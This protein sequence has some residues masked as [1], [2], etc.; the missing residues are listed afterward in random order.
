MSTFQVTIKKNRE[1]LTDINPSNL[2]VDT[3]TPNML[4]FNIS[5][6][7]EKTA[8]L[9]IVPLSNISSFKILIKSDGKPTYNEIIQEGFLYPDDIQ[10]S[11]FANFEYFKNIYLPSSSEKGR[12]YLTSNSS[13]S[14]TNFSGT[15]Y[16]G[17]ALDLTHT[18]T[19]ETLQRDY[20]ACLGSDKLDCVETVE[21]TIDI[22]TKQLGC[23][24]WD[25]GNET[26]S[27]LGCEVRIFPAKLNLFVITPSVWTL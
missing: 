19:L 26:W 8:S 15:Y 21:V 1:N 10:Y 18:E 3:S 7:P 13:L 23:L 12:I 22:Q 2:T 9:E 4:S 24:Y 14:R 6:V 11:D 17:L 27:S 20:P 5:A 25:E 16:I